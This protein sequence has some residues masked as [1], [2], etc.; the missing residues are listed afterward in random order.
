LLASAHENNN[1]N[2][3]DVATGLHVKALLGHTGK[4]RCVAFSP[5][6]R[7]LASGGE[8]KTVRLWHVLTGQEL[9][10]LPVDHFV[11]NLAFDRDGKTL[12]AALHNGKVKIWNTD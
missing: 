7:T 8:D 5:D 11:N 6:G 12:A 4:V 10:A 1:V 2:I 9:L 3:W